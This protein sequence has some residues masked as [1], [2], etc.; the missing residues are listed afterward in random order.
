MFK[1]VEKY[2]FKTTPVETPDL[3]PKTLPKKNS[4]NQ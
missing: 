1:G 4:F 2:T 3:T